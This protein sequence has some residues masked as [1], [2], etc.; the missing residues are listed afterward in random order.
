ME[1]GIL[2][3]QIRILARRNR[4][5]NALGMSTVCQRLRL[6]G[7]MPAGPNG[8]SKNHMQSGSLRVLEKLWQIAPA[9]KT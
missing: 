2:L 8:G 3:R 9:Q 1:D 6:L 4:A 7:W 5:L